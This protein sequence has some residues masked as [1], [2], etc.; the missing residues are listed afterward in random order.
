MAATST[1]LK[2]IE[3]AVQ[4]H[5]KNMTAAGFKESVMSISLGV[6]PRSP[7]LELLVGRAV[8]AGVHVAVAAGNENE[9]ACNMSPAASEKAVTVGA[10][11]PADER[12]AFSNFGNCTVRI[13]SLLA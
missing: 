12:A 1:I 7:A 13:S 4:S 9:D 6:T 5:L 8:D 10:S 3:F 11:T 2:G